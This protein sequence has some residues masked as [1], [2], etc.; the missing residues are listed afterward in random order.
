MIAWL[1]LWVRGKCVWSLSLVAISTQSAFCCC[2]CCCLSRQHF[3]LNFNFGS[4]IHLHI[5][6]TPAYKCTQTLHDLEVDFSFF[7]ST[8]VFKNDCYDFLAC[9]FVTSTPNNHLRIICRMLKKSVC[10]FGPKIVS[11][12]YQW[13]RELFE[14]TVKLMSCFY[15]NCSLLFFSSEILDVFSSQKVPKRKTV[16]SN[17]P[18]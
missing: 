4:R 16:H 15:A 11:K 7:C 2:C 5:L 3:L 13:N 12:A 14:M 18:L 1:C 9:Q 6:I 17:M 8:Y 10:L